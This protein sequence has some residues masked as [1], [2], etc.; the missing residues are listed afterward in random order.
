MMK[1][2]TA[3]VLAAAMAA[4]LT[5]CGGNGAKETTQAAAQTSQEAATVAGG[6]STTDGKEPVTLRF[7]WWG[8]ETRHKATMA[9]VEAFE[10][11]YPW[12]TVECEYSSW[13]GW[14]DKV[15]TQLAG[16][17]APDLMQINWNW[18]YQFSSDGSKFADLN[19]FKDIISLRDQLGSHDRRRKA[20]GSSD[21]HHRKASDVQQDY[22]R[23]GRCCHSHIF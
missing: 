13:D 21:F 23:Q 10:Q 11:E 4:S 22:L 6:A 2:I 8:G 16:G 12:V 9:A 20:S 19:Q 5:A 1:R 17:T 18:L 15:A 3:A 14:T 7:S